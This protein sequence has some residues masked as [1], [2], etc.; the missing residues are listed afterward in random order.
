MWQSSPPSWQRPGNHRSARWLAS[1]FRAQKIDW[2]LTSAAKIGASKSK[3]LLTFR[4]DVRLIRQLVVALDAPGEAGNLI[5]VAVLKLDDHIDALYRFAFSLARD[6]HIAEDLTQETLLK[7]CQR[8]NQ[9][10]DPAATRSWFIKICLNVW[11]DKSRRRTEV[12][13]RKTPLDSFTADIDPYEA[14][15][16][17]EQLQ[18]VFSAMDELPERQRQVLYL[19]C[20]EQFSMEMISEALDISVGA[21]KTNLSH[22]RKTMRQKF[23][24]KVT[25]FH[26]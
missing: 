14:L 6:P 12:T 3:F 17:N 5:R 10:A 4:C 25:S 11:R 20:V 1:S 8:E 16:T 9:L 22:A 15:A 13:T 23:F 24:D 7:A 26:E 21:A 19:R 2:N 18:R